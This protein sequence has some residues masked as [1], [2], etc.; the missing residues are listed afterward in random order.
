MGNLIKDFWTYTY[1]Q[2]SYFG[3]VEVVKGDLQFRKA[4][5][6]YETRVERAFQFLEGKKVLSHMSAQ[7]YNNYLN[8]SGKVSRDAEEEAYYPFFLEFEPR[9][10]PGNIGFEDEYKQAASEVYRTAQYL[11]YEYGVEAEDILIIITNTRSFYLFVNPRS[12]CA[13]PSKHQH[14]V[15]R[16]MYEAIDEEIGLEFVDQSHFRFNG[17][18]KTPGAYYAGGFVV[19]VSM[20]E[21]KKLYENP[22]QQKELLTRTQR[23]IIERDVPGAVSTRMTELYLSSKELVG[24]GRAKKRVSSF[25]EE[26]NVIHMPQTAGCIKKLE[27]YGAEP[28]QRNFALVSLAIAYKNANFSENQVYE[29]VQEAANRW[30]HDEADNVVASKVRTV[31]RKGY[32]FSCKYIQERM[33]LCG[34]C[35]SCPYKKGAQNAPKTKFKVS[36]HIIATL[37]EKKASLRHYKAYLIMSRHGLF[38]Q[39]FSPEEYGLAPRVIREMSNMINGV[40]TLVNGLVCVQIETGDRNYMFPITFVDKGVYEA[41]G[42]KLKP[43]LNLYTRFVYKAVGKYGM[44]RVKAATIARV[45]GHKNLS[46]TYKLLRALLSEGL[47]VFKN[48]YLFSLYFNS[49]KVVPIEEYKDTKRNKSPHRSECG[50]LKTG[51]NDHGEH[52]LYWKLSRGSP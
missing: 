48:G 23:S 13:R 14:L 25:P 35:A 49:Y 33:D 41:L 36:K 40:R 32:N 43:Y 47:A 37:G 22:I 17:L 7:S 42:E 45:L 38:G 6:K 21:L 39:L 18:I 4:E 8:K 5:G 19:P 1:N 46:S 29:I 27:A 9:R 2:N 28:G 50:Y 3:V 16:K 34:A 30:Q 52:R 44:M 51:T 11:I 15:Y 20:Q 10:K 31:F 26:S 24:S 12:Y